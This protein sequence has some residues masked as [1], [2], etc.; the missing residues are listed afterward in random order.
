[1]EQSSNKLQVFLIF[2]GLIVVTAGVYWQVHEGLTRQ[3][4]AWAFTTLHT[5]NWHPLTWL[6]LMLDCELFEAKA[7]ACHITNL[8]FHIINT[9]MLFVVLIQKVDKTLL[10]PH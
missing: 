3:G 5:A 7:Q 9:L 1:M 10:S 6:S 8:L 4:F 2:I